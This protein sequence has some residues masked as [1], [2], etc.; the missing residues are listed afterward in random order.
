MICFVQEGDLQKRQESLRQLGNMEH[1][2]LIVQPCAF[3][4]IEFLY[5][6]PMDIPGQLVSF[7]REIF[8]HAVPLS[9]KTSMEDFSKFS[10]HHYDFLVAILEQDPKKVARARKV[11]NLF[12]GS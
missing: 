8:W 11:I 1:V 10:K 7:D 5:R 9:K 3:E 4:G 6:V 2:K 12:T